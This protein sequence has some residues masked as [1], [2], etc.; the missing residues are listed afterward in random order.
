MEEAATMENVMPVDCELI[1]TV[2]VTSIVWTT[3]LAGLYQL[4]RERIR[5][6]YV[7]SQGFVRGIYPADR[8]GPQ[9]SNQQPTA[10]H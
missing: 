3:V 5:Q 2:F 10:G 1:V 9:V 6:V 7:I 4:I 8:K